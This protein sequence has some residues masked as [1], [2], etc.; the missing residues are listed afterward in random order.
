MSTATLEEL[1]VEEL[2]DL[3]SAEQQ[4]AKALPEMREAAASESLKQAFDDHLAQT[5]EHIHRLDR[6]FGF[7]GQRAKAKKC[8]GMKGLLDEGSQMIK[9]KA[10]DNPMFKDA[11]LIAAAQRVEHYEMAAYG[12]VRSYCE[13]LGHDAAAQILQQTLDEEKEADKKLSSLAMNT[14]NAQA[15][16]LSMGAHTPLLKNESD[17]RDPITEVVKERIY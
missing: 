17:R 15:A 5:E 11:G 7:L 2:K 1:L 12:T 9:K 16:G 4:I 3:Y 10:D 14:I 8:K 6:V 13:I